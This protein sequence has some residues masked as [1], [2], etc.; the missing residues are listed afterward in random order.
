MEDYDNKFYQNLQ[1]ML[2]ND[3]SVLMRTFS[4][5]TDFFGK[6]EI[7]ELKPGG[8]NIDVDNENKQE[9]VWL[10]SY[11]RLYQGVKVQID[12]FLN[13]FYE[14]IPRKYISIFDHHEIELLISGLPEIDI[15]DLK[16]N[17]E[18]K[19]FDPN[20]AEIRWFWEIMH[21]LNAT[22]KAEFL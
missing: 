8:K 22:E 5:T 9:F 3:A 19:G 11:H 13:G 1:W 7:V 4:E 18:Y 17:T 14:I 12:N 6:D 20:C 2:D 16:L 10:V 21:S 15:D